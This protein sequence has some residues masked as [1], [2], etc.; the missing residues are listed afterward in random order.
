MP[1]NVLVPNLSGIDQPVILVTNWC[2][3]LL[4]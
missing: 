3:A 1:V 4:F 2:V